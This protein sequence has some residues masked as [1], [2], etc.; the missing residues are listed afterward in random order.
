MIPTPAARETRRSSSGGRSADAGFVFRTAKFGNGTTRLSSGFSPSEI[1]S[2]FMAETWTT[3]LLRNIDPR[4]LRQL[5]KDAK[6]DKRSLNDFIRSILCAHYE[7]E[8]PPS[9]AHSTLEFGA[10]TQLLKL[11]PEL[12]QAIKSGSEESGETM[13]DLVLN[14]LEAHYTDSA[15]NNGGTP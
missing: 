9:G 8:C 6:R 11:Q 5:R 2:D 7:L 14:A 10:R 3:F 12:F 13:R 1:Y 15:P 4:L